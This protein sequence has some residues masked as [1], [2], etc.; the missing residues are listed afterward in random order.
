MSEIQA[1][2]FDFGGVLLKF[3]DGIDH[4]AIEARLGLDERTLM[5]CLYRES[6]YMD[7]QVGKCTHDEWITSVREAIKHH[8]GEKSEAVMQA[9]QDAERPLNWD[10]IRLAGRLKQ[11]GYRTGIISNTIPG[12]EDRL[13]ELD[14]T[15]PPERQLIPLFD[16]RIGSGDL[17]FAK[18]DPEIYLHA[19]TSLGLEPQT[20]VFTDDVAT[21]AE[22]AQAS[23]C[24]ASTSRATSNSSRTC[25]R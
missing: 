1:V 5:R 12:M 8:C 13:R 20:C 6:R 3:M 7:L 17:G 21:Y 14:A 4:K 10:M 18:P 16:V 25:A 24:T 23:G 2:F 15:Q 9:W 22:A 11:A 19:A